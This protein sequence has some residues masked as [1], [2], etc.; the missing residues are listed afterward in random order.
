MHTD[1]SYT[2]SYNSQYNCKSSYNYNYKHLL[3]ATL[4]SLQLMGCS[5]FGFNN[6]PALDTEIGS[7]AFSYNGTITHTRKVK[8]TGNVPGAASIPAKAGASTAAAGTSANTGAGADATANTSQTEEAGEH[9]LIGGFVGLFNKNK[10]W[11][12]KEQEQ[13]QGGV[14]D[15]AQDKELA[16]EGI[17]YTVKLDEVQEMTIIQGHDPVFNIGQKVKI[18]LSK[19]GPARMILRDSHGLASVSTSASTL[20]PAPAPATHAAPEVPMVT[21]QETTHPSL[22]VTQVHAEANKPL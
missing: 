2:Y 16:N 19:N 4:L 6:K 1:Y 8:I 13:E 7:T 11:G 21:A 17:E 10:L 5:T 22:P 9:S 20:A 3:I 14:Q 15:G 18:L 12:N